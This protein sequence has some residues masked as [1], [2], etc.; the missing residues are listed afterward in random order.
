MK[1]L[2]TLFFTLLISSLTARAAA[3]VYTPNATYRLAKTVTAGFLNMR[4]AP[5]AGASVVAKVFPT[6]T[7]GIIA[8][9][10]VQSTKLPDRSL[11][12][13]SVAVEGWLEIGAGGTAGGKIRREG[14]IVRVL[15]PV[16][17]KVAEEKGPL[18]EFAAG[19][20][21]QYAGAEQGEPNWIFVRKTGWVNVG[22]SRQAGTFLEGK[23][24]VPG[25]GGGKPAPAEPPPVVA[26]GS[27]VVKRGDTFYSIATRYRVSVQALAAANP[28]V[29]PS[30]IKIGQL[31]IIPKKQ[32]S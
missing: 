32:R 15:R 8:L 29:N 20:V 1:L 19:A 2:S 17:I 7:H 10:A 14:N 28:M 4:A 25:G 24:G 6:T 18:A 3:P 12:W 26:A 13:A 5:G 30:L 21:L 23:R 11:Y 31:L 22:S 9:G 16:S 27:Y